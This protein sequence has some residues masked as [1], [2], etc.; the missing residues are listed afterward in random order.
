MFHPQDEKV[1]ENTDVTFVFATILIV[2]VF[3]II[4]TRH[5]LLDH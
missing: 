1:A 2:L 4:P 3:V 5:L